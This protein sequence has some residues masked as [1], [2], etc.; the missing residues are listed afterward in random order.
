ME[1]LAAVIGAGLAVAAVAALLTAIRQAKRARTAEQEVRRLRGELSTERHAARHDHLTGLPNRRWFYGAG[2]TL[3][4]TSDRGPL[5]AILVDLDD[6]KRVNDT[7]GHRAGMKY[8][9]R[10]RAGSPPSPASDWSPGSAVTSSSP[11]SICRLDAP[12]GTPGTRDGLAES[13]GRITE[14]L[15]AP[16]PVAGGWNVAVRASIG[17]VVVPPG[18]DLDEVLDRADAAMYRAKTARPTSAPGRRAGRREAP[19]SGGWFAAD[20]QRQQVRRGGRRLRDLVGPLIRRDRPNRRRR[21]VAGPLVRSGS[22]R[23]E[24]RVVDRGQVG[25]ELGPVPGSARP[26]RPRPVTDGRQERRATG[27]DTGS[28]EDEPG[29]RARTGGV[30]A[31]ETLQQHAEGDRGLQRRQVYAEAVVR[32]DGEGQVVGRVV[33]ADVVPVG[34]GEH[35]W[36]PGSRPDRETT[37]RSPARIRTPASSVSTVA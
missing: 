2:S 9:S 14:V 22:G 18:S 3:V 6:F 34:V 11:C 21:A 10:S 8:W 36:G 35:G 32:P 15:S 16:V 31:G 30:D 25:R 29:D 33:A 7:F 19:D 1:P 12:T 27:T 17:V 4:G 23:P 13:T 28:A 37:T 5:A 24:Q 20:G 26:A